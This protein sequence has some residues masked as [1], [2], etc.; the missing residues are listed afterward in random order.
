VIARALILV[1]LVALPALAADRSRA[2]RAEFMRENPC[3]ATGKTSGA[4]P[5][6]QVDHK[7][8]LCL[9]G[10]E[11]DSIRNLQWLATEPHKAKTRED[12]RLCRAVKAQV[13]TP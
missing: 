5:G 9:G 3:P 1:L 2:L 13:V 8:P 6:W 12:V 10:P 7:V 11:V 4:C